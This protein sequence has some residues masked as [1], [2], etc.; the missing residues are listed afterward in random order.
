M[1]YIKDRILYYILIFI[2]MTV[3]AVVME[4]AYYISDFHFPTVVLYSLLPVLLIIGL[5]GML[6]EEDHRLPYMVLAV[7]AIIPI[8]YLVKDLDYEVLDKSIGEINSALTFDGPL[9]FEMFI[10]LLKILIM[11]GS[12]LLSITVSIFPFNLIIV[13][14]GIIFFLWAVD[15]YNQ[16]EEHIRMFLPVWVFSVL[17]YR[18]SIH[19][20]ETRNLRVN[21]RLRF[22]QV[23]AMSIVVILAM[24]FIDLE[25]KGVYADRIWSYV[26]DILVPTLY[27]DGSV[28][29]DPYTLASSG[30][31]DAESQLGGNVSINNNV[32]LNARGDEAIYLRGSVKTSY[33]GYSWSKDYI[34]YEAGGRIQNERINVLN[35]ITAGSNKAVKS[36]EILPAQDMTSTLFNNI[37]SREVYFSNNLSRV[38]FNRDYQVFTSNRT[39]SE[40]YYVNYYDEATVRTYLMTR[41]FQNP[42][43][44]R[45]LKYLTVPDSVPERVEE[46]VESLVDSNDSNIEKA[47]KLTD[48]LKTTYEYT[49]RPGSTPRN[50]DFIDYFLFTNRTGYCVHFGTALTIMLR[51]AGVPSRY[52]EGFKMSEE[53]NDAG[54]FIIRNSDAHA[55]T[56]VLVDEDNDLWVTFDATGTP[57][58]Q[59]NPEIVPGAPGPV[60]PGE[61]TPGTNV[62]VPTLPGGENEPEDPD[63]PIGSETPVDEVNYGLYLLTLAGGILFLMLLVKR[64]RLEIAFHS[65]SL[66][67]F[68][69]IVV[70]ALDDAYEYRKKGETDLEF[71]ARIHDRDIR[72]TFLRLTH[73]AYREVYGGAAGNFPKRRQFYDTIYKRVRRLRGL[74]YYILKRYLV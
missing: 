44:G 43:R 74:P 29:D 64:I 65:K 2:N 54:E 30:Y 11:G 26:N 73:E 63:V 53:R 22:L 60:D 34:G 1:R 66:R 17:L 10:P 32:V 21:K 46:L 49:L 59:E 69:G 25:K 38:F 3:F 6:K 51:I 4:K 27:I 61:V 57:R 12:L 18:S 67:N 35:Q 8:V 7:L 14:T 16:A 48:Y 39:T 13:D 36:L 31:N 37:Y 45:N 58:E 42:T 47:R 20:A 40:D 24:S 5:F 56:E 19:D 23:A 28:I 62:P 71:A 15:Y 68:H 70:G 55:W 33:T 41:A 72:E 52:V 50:R 9:D